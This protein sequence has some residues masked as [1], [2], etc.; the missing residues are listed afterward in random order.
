MRRKSSAL[1]SDLQSAC[2]RFENWRSSRRNRS[3]IP[4]ALWDMAV[5]VAK[6]HGVYHVAK[7]LRLN[8]E[9]LKRRVDAA[10]HPS[11]QAENRI[12]F[13]EVELGRPFSPTECTIELE[14]CNG[15][16]MTIRLKGSDSVDVIALSNAF[17]GR[18]R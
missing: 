17:L 13:V 4:E 3:R 14:A 15:T 10:K 12:P 5:P 11:P 16:K 7:T 9:G 1:P 8:Y 6:V 18:R 2:K